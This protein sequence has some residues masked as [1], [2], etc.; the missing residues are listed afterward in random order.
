MAKLAEIA[1]DIRTTKG[2]RT[3]W[4]IAADILRRKFGPFVLR[5]HVLYRCDRE[6]LR[7]YPW[8]PKIRADFRLY[9]TREAVPEVLWKR[10]REDDTK[11]SVRIEFARGAVLWAAFVDGQP[12]AYMLSIRASCLAKWYIRLEPNDVILYGAGTFREWRG[13]GL[14]TDIM[15][16]AISKTPGDIYCDAH[17]WNATAQKNFEKCGFVAFAKTH[18]EHTLSHKDLLF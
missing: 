8:Q 6:Q 9:E 1:T 17:E 5:G 16:H 11:S 14:H 12:A 3:K 15:R 10:L 18:A 7:A 13:N 2:V 4:R